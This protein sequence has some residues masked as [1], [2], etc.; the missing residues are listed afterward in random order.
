[1][2]P[3]W[4]QRQAVVTDRRLS[5]LLFYSNQTA[6]LT[7]GSD[8]CREQTALICPTFDRWKLRRRQGG[9]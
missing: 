1:M 9:G 4:E 6:C 3:G 7:Q 5:C 8:C 2:G